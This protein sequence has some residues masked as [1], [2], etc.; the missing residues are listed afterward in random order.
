MS[1]PKTARGL[2]TRDKILKAAASEFGSKGYHETGITDITKTAGVALGT[3][4]TYYKSKEVV[5]RAL[6]SHMGELTR[7]WIAK[8]IAGAPDR[9][10]AERMGIAA[11]IE[12]AREHKD[13]YR[14]IMEAQFVAKDSYIEYYTVFAESYARNLADA[15]DKGEIRSGHDEERAWALIGMSVFLG[16]KYGVWDES[17][18]PDDIA[19]AIGDLLENGLGIK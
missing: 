9:L 6:V 2:R 11:F 1:E 12:F 8:R 14:I 13:L 10:T 7:E 3:F 16:L 18:D 19:D 4:Y 17:R 5:F 15:A